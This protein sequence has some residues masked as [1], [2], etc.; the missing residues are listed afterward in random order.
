VRIL[1]PQGILCAW[2]PL[3]S[4]LVA[5]L[6]AGRVEGMKAVRVL[7]CIGEPGGATDAP[8]TPAEIPRGWSLEHWPDCE[9]FLVGFNDPPAAMGW[10][11]NSRLL[12][13]RRH[14]ATE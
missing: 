11:T 9:R 3:E 6:L 2:P 13:Y 14:I 4:D 12:V 7:V 5:D 1:A 10:G 8:A